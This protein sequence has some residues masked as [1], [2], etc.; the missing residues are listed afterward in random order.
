MNP[1]TPKTGT[2]YLIP[3]PIGNLGDITLRAIEV[4]KRVDLLLTEDTR[5]TRKLLTHFEI[6]T[7]TISYH[8]FSEKKKLDQILK[9]LLNNKSVALV[10]DAGMPGISDPGTILVSACYEN[11]IPVEVLPGASAGIT[12]LVASGF[13]IENHLFAGFL[14]KKK[15]ELDKKLVE[16]KEFPGAVVIYVSVHQVQKFLMNLAKVMPDR[17]VHV[18][19]EMTKFFEEHIRGTASEVSTRINSKKPKGEYVIILK[20]LSLDN[21]GS[22]SDET[23]IIEFLEYCLSQGISVKTAADLYSKATGVNRSAVYRV[24]NSRKKMNRK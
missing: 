19:R 5:V 17:F 14:P 11:D 9:M 20:P 6:K 21:K 3:T 2:L 4:M 16:L 18:A 23:D 15:S 8:G 7:G 22:G 12:A 24:M 1:Q 10:S 13:V